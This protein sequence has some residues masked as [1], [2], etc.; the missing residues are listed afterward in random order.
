MFRSRAIP[1]G[2]TLEGGRWISFLAGFFAFFMRIAMAADPGWL[3][4][5][6]IRGVDGSVRAATLWDRDGDGPEPPRLVIGG[7]FA[8][9]GTANASNIALWNGENWEPLGAGTTPGVSGEITALVV[10]PDGSLVA[11]GAFQVAGGSL[12]MKVARWDGTSWSSLGSGIG[13]ASGTVVRTMVV[14]GDGSLVVAGRFSSAGGNPAANIARWDGESWSSVGGGFSPSNALIN[15]LLPSGANGLIAC[16]SFSVAGGV[17]T[18]G[19]AR[20]TGSVWEPLGD[21]IS[22]TVHDVIRLADGDLLAAGGSR[23]VQRWNGVSWTQASQGLGSTPT[24][25]GNLADGTVIAG[26]AT[27]IAQWS[28]SQWING[29]GGAIHGTIQTLLSL[30]DGSLLAGGD[31][32]KAGDIQAN[33][34]ARYADG[35]WQFF[36]SGFGGDSRTQ[37]FAFLNGPGHEIIAGGS[38]TA[39]G[40]IEASKVARWDGRRWWP[41]G[42]GVAGGDVKALARMP[43][44]SVIAGGS[45]RTAEGAPAI[46]VARWDGKHWHALGTGVGPAAMVVESLAVTPSGELIACGSFSSI[47]GISAT[48]LARWDGETWSRIGGGNPSTALA[49][50]VLDNGD[51]VV[52]GEFSAIAGQAAGRIARWNGSEWSDMGG[53]MNGGVY[54]LHPLPG[55]RLL[56]AGRF[57][58]A[59]GNP[60]NRVAR[61]DGEA[62]SGVGSGLRPS[63]PT[64]TLF[65]LT[66]LADNDILIGGNFR[67]TAST[68]ENLARLRDGVWTDVGT[69]ADGA[70]DSNVYALAPMPDG[71][72]VVGGGFARIDGN[73]AAQ[74]ARWGLPFEPPPFLRMRNVAKTAAGFRFGFDGV[75]GRRYRIEYSLNLLEWTTLLDDVEGTADYLYLEDEP[76]RRAEPNGFY[77]VTEKP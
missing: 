75:P 33:R 73:V 43:D 14:L 11:G 22:A 25:L 12:A 51:I 72:F 68:T 65:A 15:K 10:L 35:R 24:V 41:M 1:S 70:F 3:P 74:F 67:L 63:S 42:G 21:G 26:G 47:G 56:A 71:G 13:P 16:G 77:R 40:S 48:N 9:A 30:P 64:P 39:A 18:P 66:V 46:G 6:G 57:G 44:G 32:L 60:A 58:T 69:G 54:A 8:I 27:Q 59:G 20:W 29:L 17:S 5:E 4:A 31:F 53:G 50:A 23:R 37:I 52:G 55:G 7:V 19:I 45:F 49:V 76:S 2:G 34:M 38:F 62:W 28:G 61:W 36:G